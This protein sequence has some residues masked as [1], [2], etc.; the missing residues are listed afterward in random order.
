MS[1]L[2]NTANRNENVRLTK[3]ALFIGLGLILFIF[4]TLIPR[5]LPWL[6]LG[7]AH[8]VTLLALYL[9]DARAAVIVVLG[10]IFLGSLMLGTFFNPT[11]FLSL[12]GGL[13]ATLLMIILKNQCHKIFSI[14]GVSIAGAVTHNLI[15]LFVANWLIIHKTEIFYLI[16]LLILAAIFTGFIVAFISQFLIA[17]FENLY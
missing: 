1:S 9:L 11:F 10:R 16:P 6:K 12:S 2:N 13:G 3:I 14:F 8:I 5:P 17:T 7:F 15:Q 4:E